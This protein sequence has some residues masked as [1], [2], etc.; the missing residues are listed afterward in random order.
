MLH[1]RGGR[2]PLTDRSDPYWRSPTTMSLP[3]VRLRVLGPQES[4]FDADGLRPITIGRDPQCQ[5]RLTSDPSLSRFHCRLEFRPPLCQ[6]IDLRSANGTFVNNRPVREETLRHGDEL[7]CGQTRIRI[8]ISDTP[9]TPTAKRD[10]AGQHA[11]AEAPRHRSAPMRM[12]RASEAPDSPVGAVTPAELKEL[13]P[14]VPSSLGAYTIVREIGRGAMG[15]VLLATHSKTGRQV[16]IKLIMTETEADGSRIGLFVREA[17]V[18]S[19][20]KHRRIVEVLDFGMLDHRPY[21][22]L[23]HLP[24]VSLDD[25]LSP[26]S[27]AGRIRVLCRLVGRVL[28]ALE[29]AHRSGYVHRDVKP[30]NLLIHRFGLND[31]LRVKLGDF[32]LAKSYETAGLSGM[33]GSAETRGTVAFMPPEQLLD[34]R[35]AG[36]ECDIYSTGATLYRLLAGIGPYPPSSLADLILAIL[37]T[38][39]PP[40]RDLVPDVSPELASL[41]HRALA[42]EP[43]D[44]FPSAQAMRGAL[45]AIVERM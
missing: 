15:R 43:A 33:T 16:A 20:L 19:R 32:G 26:M 3:R 23:E 27:V 29:F 39:P 6:V 5:L 45:S 41:V 17:A 13:D 35:S 11:G 18:L 9:G 22:V 36:P 14:K 25:V 30:S 44:R 2:L 1:D 12:I 34:S 38:E 42:R 10:A 37:S 24:I 7:R 21:L 31:K 28:E 40:L 8:E 4:V